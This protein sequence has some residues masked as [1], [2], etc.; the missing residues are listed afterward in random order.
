MRV[1]C[2][3]ETRYPDGST[4][5]GSFHGSRRH[6]KGS[7]TH[8]NGNIYN[9]EFHEDHPHGHGELIY[10]CTVEGVALEVHDKYVGQ[11]FKGHP[12]KSDNLRLAGLYVFKLLSMCWQFVEFM[13]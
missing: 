6:G 12:V 4:Y 13:F 3:G 2:E 10:V 1:D 11:F 9:G 7:L 5:R 8:S